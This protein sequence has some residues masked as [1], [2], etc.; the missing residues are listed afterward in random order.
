M[1]CFPRP[2]LVRNAYNYD[3]FQD[4]IDTGLECLEPTLAQQQFKDETDINILA[5]RFGLTGTMPMNPGTPNYGDFSE[6]FDFQ[7]SMNA[8]VKARQDFM[9]LP[10]KLRKRFDNDP[11]QLLLF[12]EDPANRSEAVALGLVN[13]P[14]VPPQPA[15]APAPPSAS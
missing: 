14:P 10:P 13:P 15:P 7:T 4:S 5:E 12:M 2:I 3:V 6:V 1:Y 11:Q 8:I 9:A